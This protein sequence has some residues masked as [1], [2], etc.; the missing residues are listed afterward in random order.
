MGVRHDSA[1]YPRDQAGPGPVGRGRLG[2]RPG[3][4]R[5]R[6]KRPGCRLEAGE[7]LAMTTPETA[8]PATAVSTAA[9]AASTAGPA[10]S[11]TATG[12][13][14]AVEQRLAELGLTLPDVAA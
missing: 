4:Y 10:E 8:A 3:C 2:G 13:S 6:W 9:P 14:S 1:H 5:P 11:A 12:A 7:E